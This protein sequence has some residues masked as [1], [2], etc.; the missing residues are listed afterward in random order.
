MTK[1]NMEK[2][3]GE[4][5]VLLREMFGEGIEFDCTEYFKSNEALTGIA[6]HL[7]GCSSVLSTLYHVQ[8][9]K[10]LPTWPAV[11]G[12]IGSPGIVRMDNVILGSMDNQHGKGV[13]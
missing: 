8:V 2:V 12:L 7:P 5:I 6:L 13:G 4:A 11:V 3:A 1:A 9:D 10:L